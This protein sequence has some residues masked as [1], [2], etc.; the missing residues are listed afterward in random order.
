MDLQQICN[1]VVLFGAVA[2]ALTNI[3]KF[4][5]KPTTFYKNKRDKEIDQKMQDFFEELFPK[6][7]EEHDLR[8]RD[9]YRADR[10]RYLEEISLEV[11]NNH[12]ETLEEIKQIVLNQNKSISDLNQGIKDVLREKIMTIYDN[13]KKDCRITREKK[14]ILDELYKDYT[15]IGGNSYITHYYNRVE[16]DW[17]V[18]PDM[19]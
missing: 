8:T 9:K 4:F 5:I 12:K 19:D 13:G 6:Y 1:W 16:E 17:E 2:V 11:E 3:I 10:Q 14:E 15:A 18:I 7:L